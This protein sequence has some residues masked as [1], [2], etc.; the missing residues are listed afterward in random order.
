MADSVRNPKI[1]GHLHT[2]AFIPTRLNFRE[3]VHTPSLALFVAVDL[4]CRS[5]KAI[6][7]TPLPIDTPYAG[8]DN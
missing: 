2:E 3:D 1:P 6:D 8:E 5:K 4:D 7:E